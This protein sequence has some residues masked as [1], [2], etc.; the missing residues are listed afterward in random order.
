M[1]WDDNLS[2]PV[3]TL[4]TVKDAALSPSVAEVFSALVVVVDDVRVRG[5]AAVLPN[6]PVVSLRSPAV[7]L[8]AKVSDAAH[9]PSTAEVSSA[10][11]VLS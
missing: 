4:R 11:A 7:G 5:T 10:D 1:T 9:P 2:T 6:Y 8:G 3:T